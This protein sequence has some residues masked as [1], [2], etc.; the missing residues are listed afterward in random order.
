MARVL[1]RIFSPGKTTAVTIAINAGMLAADIKNESKQ[2]RDTARTSRNSP[3][4]SPNKTMTGGAKTYSFTIDNDKGE[5][6]CKLIMHRPH[7]FGRTDYIYTLVI[8]RDTVV[9]EQPAE[10]FANSLSM[11]GEELFNLMNKLKYIPHHDKDKNEKL[12]LDK[13]ITALKKKHSQMIDEAKIKN[14]RSREAI[15][16]ADIH[17]SPS[18]NLNAVDH[19]KT[20]QV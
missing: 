18:P 12:G 11:S 17:S 7:T 13:V 8:N 19:P 6:D 20:L 14:Q 1:S 5:N 16:L 10:Q 9:Q 3:P 2:K 4:K 15:P